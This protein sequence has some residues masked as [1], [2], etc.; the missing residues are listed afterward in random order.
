MCRNLST[1]SH[2]PAKEARLQK[3]LIFYSAFLLLFP[4]IVS[5]V[6]TSNL[7]EV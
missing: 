7:N 1:H 4:V 2:L 6:Q 3:R 5:P